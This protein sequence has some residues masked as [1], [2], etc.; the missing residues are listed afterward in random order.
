V[1]YVLGAAQRTTLHAQLLTAEPEDDYDEVAEA[2]SVLQ[3][4][5][6]AWSATS[7]LIDQ[8]PVA[9]ELQ[10]HHFEQVAPEGG[11]AIYVHG[12]GSTVVVS[13]AVVVVKNRF[14]SPH[15]A[16]GRESPVVAQLRRRWRNVVQGTESPVAVGYFVKTT[17]EHYFG[18]PQEAPR[19]LNISSKV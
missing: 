3:P 10:G 4:A 15:G 11:Q 8:T 5:L 18:G 13:D 7:E 17:V 6:D 9:F 14:P 2:H 19:T 12:I 16:I 1:R